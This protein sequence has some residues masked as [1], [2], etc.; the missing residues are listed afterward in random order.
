MKLSSWDGEPFMFELV[1]TKKGQRGFKVTDD[2]KPTPI[3]DPVEV[4]HDPEEPIK[5]PGPPEVPID[6]P[7]PEPIDPTTPPLTA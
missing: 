5:E 1:T 4:P 3:D 7:L 2:P 6:D